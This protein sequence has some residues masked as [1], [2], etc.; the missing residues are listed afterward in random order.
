MP[1]DKNVYFFCE[2]D[3]GYRQSLHS[4]LTSSAGEFLHAAIEMSSNDKLWVKL[5]SAIDPSDAHAIDINIME[6]VGLIM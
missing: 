6:S 2:G 4:V 5:S 3:A 1:Y